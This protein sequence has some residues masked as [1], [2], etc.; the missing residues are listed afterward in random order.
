LPGPISIAEAAY[1]H[2]PD[3]MSETNL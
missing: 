2:E 1:D 3:L